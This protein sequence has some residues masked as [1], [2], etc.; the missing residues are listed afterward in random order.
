MRR[1]QTIESVPEKDCS[2]CNHYKLKIIFMGPALILP[3]FPFPFG[4]FHEDY[5]TKFNRRLLNTKTPCKECVAATITMGD[6]LFCEKRECL[7][8]TKKI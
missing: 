8:F 1:I 5:C 6:V 3:M 4:I 2:E 7:N